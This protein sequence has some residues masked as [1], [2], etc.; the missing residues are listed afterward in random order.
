MRSYILPFLFLSLL[1]SCKKSNPV[2]AGPAISG[3]DCGSVRYNNTPTAGISFAG[4][5][6]IQYSGGNGMAYPAGTVTASSGVTGLNVN[7][8]AGTLASGSGL[9]SFAVSGT[10]SAP[11]NARFDIG[12]GSKSCSIILPVAENTNF[13]QYGTPFANVP[14]RKEVIIYQVNMRAFS[15]T[16]NFQGVTDRLDSIKAMGANVIYLMPVFPVGVVNAFN[17]PYCVKDYRSVNTEFG[18]L[19]DLRT[20]VDG[21]HARNMSVMLDWV[22][23]HTSWD[24]SWITEHSDWYQ[25]N[26]AGAIISPPGMGWNDVAQLDYTNASM[27]LEMIRNLKYWVYTANVDGFRFDYSDG[28]PFSFWQQAVDSLRNISTHKLVLLAEGSRADHYTAGFDFIFGFNFYGG[29]RNVF[30]NGQPATIFDALNNTEFTGAANGQQ[31]VRYT[32]NHDVNGS[33]GTPQELFGG[34]PGSISAFIAASLMKGVPMIY[35]GQEVG[36]PIRLTFPFTSADINWT[37]NPDLKATYKK[38]LSFRNSSAAVR[39]GTLVS[40][41]NANILAFTKELGAEKVCILSNVRN[42]SINFNLPGAL[43]GTS[44]TDVMTGTP[45]SLGTTVSLPAY[46]YLLLKN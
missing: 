14:D 1:F 8:Q 29:L 12:F 17:S 42:S 6:T 18:T 9:I 32:T 11:G 38:I 31:V 45:V 21:A 15:S 39:G 20:L 36:T 28:P 34:L 22:A 40:Y 4:A 7:L 46:G 24:H 30:G 33:D 26:T 27:R 35:N 3:L 13:V 19:A 5:I 41:S 2:N 23:N 16:G 44:W 10:A 37:L 43:S 25:K